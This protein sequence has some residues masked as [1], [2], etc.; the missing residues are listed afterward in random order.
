MN[1]LQRWAH[2]W[3]V[4]PAALADLR[5]QI[6]GSAVPPTAGGPSSEAGVQS[7]VRLEAARRGI[8]LWRNNVGAG[9][10]DGGAY[11]RWGLCNDSPA[12]N[13]AVKSADLIG[14]KP[15]VVTPAMVGCTVGQFASY[16]IK[17]AGWKWR[18]DDHEVAQMAWANLINTL[19]GD[20]RFLTSAGDL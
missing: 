11:L 7:A 4:T 12:I 20:A 10:V 19:G 8:R 9:H 5:D 2:K 16:E 15:L 18:G 13:R 17:H 14:I 6:S 3:G 1:A